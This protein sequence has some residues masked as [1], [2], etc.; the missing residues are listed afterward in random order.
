VLDKA[1]PPEKK[2]KPKRSLIVILAVLEAFFFAVI[3]AFFSE[4]MERAKA[5]PEQTE[6]MLALRSAFRFGL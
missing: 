3:W 6:I 2:S 4:A 1:I 5:Q